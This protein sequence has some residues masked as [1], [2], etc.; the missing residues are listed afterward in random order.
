LDRL[1][2]RKKVILAAGD[3]KKYTILPLVP[4]TFEMA[5]ITPDLST[6]NSWHK[7]FAE[8]FEPLYESGYWRDYINVRRA[9]VRYLPVGP[10]TKTLYQAWPSDVLEEI[11][12]PYDL[13]AV[14]QCQCRAVMQLVGKGCGKPLENCVAIGPMATPLLSRGMMRK[15]DRQEIIEIKHKAEEKGCVTWMMN[16]Q[17]SLKGNISCSC[18]GCCC[19]GLRTIRDFSAPGMI[20]K[21][22]YMPVKTDDKC[23]ACKVC[24]NRC[25]TKAWSMVDDVMMFDTIRCIGCGLCVSSCKFDALELK[26]VDDAKKPEPNYR[27]LMLKMTP[28]YI[29]NS[30]WVWARRLFS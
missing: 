17:G 26:T 19:H 2:T 11:L 29:K 30:M 12:E 7:H 1:A 14:G 16:E 15:A 21:P 5:I 22:H 18:C 9:P 6:L 13:F 24:V 28:S 4:G 3:P 23:T 25:P 27:A 10:V 20:S 8:L